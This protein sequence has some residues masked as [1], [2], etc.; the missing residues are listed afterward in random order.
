[1]DLIIP[2]YGR[3][4]RQ[5]TLA[6]L[7]KAG[8]NVTLVVQARE[9]RSYDS[10]AQHPSVRV[11]ELPPEITTIAPTR[12]WIME[13]VGNSDRICMIDDDLWFYKRRDDDRSKLREIAPEELAKAFETMDEMLAGYAHVGF[14][15]REGANRNT[16]HLMFN[17]RIMRVLGYDRRV[18]QKEGLRFDKMDVMEDFHV[19]LELLK[20]GH[21]NVVMNEYAHNQAGGSGDKGGCSHFRTPELHARNAQRLAEL[22][23]GFVTVVQKATKGA[24]GGGTRTDVRVAWKKAYD[25]SLL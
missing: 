7:V 4:T 21:A 16:E 15:A 14:A 2:T 22:H 12:Q 10:Y 6:Q 20:L 9:A 13:C 11:A 3:A 24:W 17:T 19:A 23:P 5:E 8:L 18:L 25:S 1:V